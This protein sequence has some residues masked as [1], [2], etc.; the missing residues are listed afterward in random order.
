MSRVHWY[1]V[2][3]CFFLF[4]SCQK[5]EETVSPERKNITESIYASGIVK[6]KNQY[7]VFSKVNGTIQNFFIKETDKV[8]KGAALFKVEDQNSNLNS[9]N[10]RLIA[11]ANDYNTNLG[12]LSDA[13]IAIDLARK[14]T[15]NDSLLY[16]RQQNL[17]QKNIGSQF[18]FEQRQLNYENSKTNLSK[19]I[20]YHDDLQR[21]LKLLSAQSKN[22]LKIAETI[23]SD[24]I[25]RSEIDGIVYQINAEPGE[26]VSPLKPIA[27]IGQDQ[28]IIELS[29][30]E[31]DIV[32][33]K[34]GQKIMIRMDSYK[35]DV[36]EA[37]V[38]NI[39]PMMNSRTRSFKVEAEFTKKPDQLYPNLS[40]EAN[41]IV[42]EKKDALTIPS[43][44]LQKDSTVL[45][46]NGNFKKVSLGLSDYK[47]TEILGGIDQ[48]DKLI[49]PKQ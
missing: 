43:S 10:S 30:D 38:S 42:Q 20:T 26:M 1:S 2:L 34:K 8:K 47:L 33:L 28:F 21:Q 40:L 13:K 41:I 49:M 29:V 14:K 37:V 22:N 5:K 6:S 3:V 17:W 12:K 39:Y 7:E 9:A 36:F 23:A 11:A 24:F 18:E 46:S 31:Y 32:K 35:A 27:V 15:E 45:L 44:Y 4:L 25:I 19:A 16:I 48:T